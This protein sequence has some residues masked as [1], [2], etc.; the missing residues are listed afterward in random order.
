MKLSGIRINRPYPG[1]TFHA[2]RLES[3]LLN[4][5]IS[6]GG[7]DPER[8]IIERFARQIEKQKLKKVNIGGYLWTISSK[9]EIFYFKAE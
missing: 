9:E 1:E 2:V 4:L 5:I 3:A 6:K 7:E 8:E